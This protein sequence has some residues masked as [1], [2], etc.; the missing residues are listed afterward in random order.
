MPASRRSSRSRSTPAGATSSDSSV[1]PGDVAPLLASLAPEEGAAWGGFLRAHARLTA[2]LDGE[3]R[4]AMTRRW[5]GSTRSSNSRSHRKG[6]GGSPNLLSACSYRRAASV[7]SWTDSRPR[8]SWRGSPTR[9]TAGPR[10]VA[11]T[12]D[13][14]ARLHAVH[15]THV[16]GIR[17]HFLTH[18][19]A[20]DRRGLGALWRRLVVMSE[21][22]APPAAAL[23]PDAP[24]PAGGRPLKDMGAASA[25]PVIPCTRP[26]RW[27]TCVVG[28]CGAT[29]MPQRAARAEVSRS[30]LP[31]TSWSEQPARADIA[32]R[33]AAR[34]HDQPRST[35]GVGSTFVLALPLARPAAAIGAD[36]S[37][38]DGRAARAPRWRARAPEASGRRAPR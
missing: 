37:R 32:V 24:P 35:L 25:S 28:R 31:E 13:G 6:D 2:V 27:L 26:T 14:W 36:V 4:A 33:S 15:A 38:G 23:P 9:M 1:A 11:L 17:R 7:G 3:L 34:P 8:R 10:P 19:S 16:A 22:D 30:G 18:L 20:A 21:K 29:V 12:R 5:R